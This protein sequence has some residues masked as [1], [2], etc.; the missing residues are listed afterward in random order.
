MA[1]IKT[2]KEF[3][4]YKEDLPENIFKEFQFGKDF[5]GTLG[6]E[7]L[8]EQ[9][10]INEKFMLGEQ[11]DGA[12]VGDMPTPVMNI[13][14]QIIDYKIANL[15]SNP[16]E[17][18]FSFEGVP[19]YLESKD[20]LD[21]GRV[22]QTLEAANTTDLMGNQTVPVEPEDEFNAVADAMSAHCRTVWER[23][24]MNRKNQTG[25]RKAA[26][27]GTYVLYC[28]FD[29]DITTGLY[30]SDGE[31]PIKG[32]ISSQILDITN[33]YFG[34]PAET[35][36]Q[37]QPSIIISQ[38][39]GVR[40]VAR[41]AKL[42]NVKATDIEKILE[43]TDTGYEAGNIDEDAKL[44]KKTTLLTK[45]WKEYQTDGSYKVN[46][47]KCAKDVVIQ[48]TFDIGIQLYPLSVFQWDE[49][50][51]C[52]YGHSEV[53]ELIPN[54]TCVNR[55]LAL[56]ILAT[57][58]VGMPK[59]IFN[60]EVIDGSQITNDP[61][62]LIEVRSAQDVHNAIAYL[63]PAQVSPNFNNIQQGMIDNTKVIAGATQAA[64]GDLRPENTSAIIA[65]REAATLPLQPVLM[66]FHSFVE[67]VARIWGEM[68]LKKYGERK[69][70][71]KKDGKVYYV[72]FNADKYTNM[73]LS[74]KIE[75]GTSTIW[76][77]STLIATL[78]NLLMLGKIDIVDFLERVPDGFIPKR[79][80]LINTLKAR[81]QE[82]AK[83]AADAEAAKNNPQGTPTTETPPET[84][85]MNNL[86][87][88]LEDEPNA[89]ELMAAL[90]ESPDILDTVMQN[91]NGGGEQT[92]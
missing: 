3:D 87:S 31:T 52:I 56:E 12:E 64:L 28:P 36:V 49:R 8:Y 92:A 80:D 25:A 68:I 33:V 60:G 67:D 42:N 74:V 23:T 89:D 58:L 11:W 39:K 53:T 5:K 35:D 4:D 16:I 72:P 79:Q 7:G 55:L 29:A 54:Q 19:C 18:M 70:K 9:T 77:M 66:R 47:V 69:L 10:R 41:L 34:N 27:S 37:A 84:V 48:E 32:D 14:K 21:V 90:Q 22:Q 86:L 51:N 38:R 30:S 26:I 83:M 78:N 2:K 44:L 57:M 43:D 13:I 91:A 15:T 20:K 61:G 81:Q 65:L 85:D 24:Q 71:I 50:D 40:E 88:S 17:F 45:F 75:V 82:M 73:L 76:S 63:N 6:A 1:E 59:T 62:D 46:C